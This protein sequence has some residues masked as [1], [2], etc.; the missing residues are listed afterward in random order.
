MRI[1]EGGVTSELGLKGFEVVDQGNQ[2]G[3]E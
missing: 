1:Q 2:R 3:W